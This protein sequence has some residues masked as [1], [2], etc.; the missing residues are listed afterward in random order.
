MQDTSHQGA[1][2]QRKPKHILNQ[3]ILVQ[4]HKKQQQHHQQKQPHAHINV[5]CNH[6]SAMQIPVQIKD[7]K[8]MQAASCLMMMAYHLKRKGI[9]LSKNV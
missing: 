7:E 5:N 3:Y 9:P 4:L 1:Q 6:L 8:K 2:T